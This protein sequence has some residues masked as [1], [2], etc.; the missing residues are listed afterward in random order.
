MTVWVDLVFIGHVPCSG[1]GTVIITNGLCD[2]CVLCAL[3]VEGISVRVF[4]AADLTSARSCVDL[5]DCVVRTINVR[6]DT[7]AEK[8]LVVVCIDA[9]VDLGSPSLRILTRVHGVSVQNTSEL[10]FQL[11]GTILVEDPV[12]AVLVICSRED[13]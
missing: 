6:I 7:K 1:G 2:L 9:G 8:M 12:Y 11:N 10:D 5:E 3:G 4:F 13:V